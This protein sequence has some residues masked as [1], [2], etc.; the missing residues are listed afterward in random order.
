MSSDGIDSHH[1]TW[2][3]TKVVNM[4]TKMTNY[5]M[6]LYV[7]W[8]YDVTYGMVTCRWSAAWR[9]WTPGRASAPSLTSS[10]NSSSRGS[11]GWTPSGI[12][13]FFLIWWWPRTVTSCFQVEVGISLIP[14]MSPV[15]SCNSNE[16]CAAFPYLFG[17]SGIN[18][19]FLQC[20]FIT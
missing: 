15:N 16:W 10:N 12:I 13:Y 17:T 2:D 8:T 9:S 20:E 3:I 7:M 1:L 4:M 14:P 6:A 11:P 19:P 5:A 18:W